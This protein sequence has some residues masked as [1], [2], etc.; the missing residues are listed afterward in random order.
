MN[1]EIESGSLE[2]SDKV[3]RVNG[4]IDRL[5]SKRIAGWAIDRADPN[6]HVD[7]DI[8]FEDILIGQVAASNYRKDLE[9]NG[10]GTGRY[11]F[12]F[13]LEDEIDPDMSFAISAIA[14]TKDGSSARLRNTGST[15]LS[16]DPETRLS[17]RAYLNGCALRKELSELSNALQTMIEMENA[18]EPDTNTLDRIELVQ[19][20]LETILPKTHEPNLVNNFTGLKWAVFVALLF[21]MASLGVGVF[22]VWTG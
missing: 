16:D 22:S 18:N 8:Y 5:G 15:M 12:K 21:G 3:E 2:Q 13:E 11:G 4:I 1:K 7:V 6:A 19:A 14:R 17:Q 20:R 9:K 10:I